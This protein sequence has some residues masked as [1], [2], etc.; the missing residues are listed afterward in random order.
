MQMI[1]RLAFVATLLVPAVAL[2]APA[3]SKAKLSDADVRV[4]AHTHAVDQA[5][6][7]MSKLAQKNGGTAVKSFGDTLGKA[8]VNADKHVA[9]FAKTRGLSA[10]PDGTASPDDAAVQKAAQAT[11][12][13]LSGLK[14]AA[15]DHEFLAAIAKEEANEVAGLAIEIKA[16][17]DPVVKGMMTGMLAEREAQELAAITLESS[18]GSSKPR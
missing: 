11:V 14:G 6:I 8:E 5:T 16:A 18:T 1:H 7:E 4:L 13:H 10:I 9:E 12:A 2:A 15:F 17:P 3:A